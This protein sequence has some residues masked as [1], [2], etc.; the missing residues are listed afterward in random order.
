M[1]LLTALMLAG[2]GCADRPPKDLGALP[3]DQASLSE[4]EVLAHLGAALSPEAS[5]EIQQLDQLVRADAS[6]FGSAPDPT[7]LFA[8]RRAAHAALPPLAEGASELRVLTF[9]AALLERTYLG[10]EVKMPEMD[11]RKKDMAERLL[12]L[13]Y[14][15]LLLQEIWEW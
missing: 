12:R 4:T 2:V 10:T 6:V 7:A 5:A 3:I 9:N 11:A 14:D 8:A 13:D 15:V 1:R